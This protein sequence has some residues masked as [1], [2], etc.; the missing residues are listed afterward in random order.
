[1]GGFGGGK[2]GIGE[3]KREF[4]KDYQEDM[5]IFL[6]IYTDQCLKVIAF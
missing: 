2:L 5:F 6:Y 1:M 3:G 4:L